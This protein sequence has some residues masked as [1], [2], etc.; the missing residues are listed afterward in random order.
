[1][2]TFSK[3]MNAHSHNIY[4]QFLE[5]YGSSEVPDLKFSYLNSLVTQ[6][7]NGQIFQTDRK[8]NTQ[9]Q[10]YVKILIPTSANY[11]KV[12]FFTSIWQWWRCYIPNCVFKICPDLTTGEWW[13]WGLNPRPLTS[14]PLFSS[15]NSVALVRDALYSW[16]GVWH[17]LIKLPHLVLDLSG[18]GHRSNRI[19]RKRK[20]SLLWP[21]SSS[22]HI[23]SSRG[24]LA[25][26]AASSRPLS[27][28]P[29]PDCINIGQEDEAGTIFSLGNS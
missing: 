18:G 15:F 8:G 7:N 22:G 16:L 20:W 2:S 3:R 4:I 24:S 12:L 23:L 21:S 5:I 17:G 10:K 13:S 29:G 9:S 14:N 25:Y 27:C 11:T 26:L 6:Q 1:M 28:G 19:T